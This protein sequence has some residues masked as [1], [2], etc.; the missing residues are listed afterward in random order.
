MKTVKQQQKKK[1]YEKMNK[2]V[3]SNKGTTKNILHQLKLKKYNSLQYKPSPTAKVKKL[4]KKLANQ[5]NLPTL[6]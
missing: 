3:I 4:L 5:K 2:T 1:E 6:K